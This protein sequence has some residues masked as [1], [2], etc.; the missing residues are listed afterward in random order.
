MINLAKKDLAFFGAFNPPTLAHI[1]TAEKAMISTGARSVVF[2]PSKTSY[3]LD[4]QRKDYAFDDRNRALMLLRLRNPGF[5]MSDIDIEA[6]TQPKAYDSLCRLRELHYD[7]VLLIGEDKLDELSSWYRAE[8][9]AKEFGIVCV[10]RGSDS[11]ERKCAKHKLGE[12][13]FPV[14]ASKSDTKISSTLARKLISEM[15]R[16]IV[17]LKQYVP[18]EVAQHIMNEIVMKELWF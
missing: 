10:E 17:K 14:K 7:P 1:H 8:D 4:Q 9:I 16:D 6:E 13:I 5:I 12:Y 3:I 18:V 2:V 11:I 15:R